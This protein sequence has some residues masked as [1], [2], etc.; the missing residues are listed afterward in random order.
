M[1]WALASGLAALA[2]GCTNSSP[3]PTQTPSSTNTPPS[4]WVTDTFDA[5]GYLRVILKHPPEWT[6]QLVPYSLHYVELLGFAANWRLGPYCHYFAGGGVN[7]NE[8]F[9]GSPPP[10]GVILSV[11]LTGCGPGGCQT[12][13][14]VAGQHLTINGRAAR[15]V[16]FRGFCGA[17]ADASHV[18]YLIDDGAG[19]GFLDVTVCYLPTAGD[20][21]AATA[22]VVAQTVRIQTPGGR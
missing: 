1:R 2:V 19:Q 9:L 21:L 8:P 6:R 22:D 14:D 10:G 17:A 20:G 18:A 15:R 13:Q 3:A 16:S 4:G 7:C 12:L 11:A 5:N